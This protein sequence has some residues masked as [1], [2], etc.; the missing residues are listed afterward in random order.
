MVGCP[1]RQAAFFARIVPLIRPMDRR[2]SL[3]ENLL[4]A[5]CAHEH[6]WE[7]SH[8]DRLHNMFGVTH[9]GGNNMAFASDQ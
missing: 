5:L 4:L 6:G 2:L 7:D 9:A 8:N 1:A 3:D